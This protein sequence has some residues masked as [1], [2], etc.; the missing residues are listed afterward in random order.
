MHEEEELDY[1]DCGKQMGEYK[2]ITLPRGHE[3]SHV[4]FQPVKFK[5]APPKRGPKRQTEEEIHAEQVEAFKKKEAK[6]EVALVE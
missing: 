1:K 5:K 3:Y 6:L 2:I 4:E